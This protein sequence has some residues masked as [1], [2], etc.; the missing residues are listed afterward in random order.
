MAPMRERVGLESIHP[1]IPGRALRNVSERKGRRNCPDRC[2]IAVQ[3]N[4]TGQVDFLQFQ[5]SILIHS[6]AVN[7]VGAGW[8]V[9]ARGNFGIGVGLVTQNA[10]GAVDFLNLDGHGNLKSSAMSNVDVAPII[11]A[12]FFSSD[13]PNQVGPTYV[14]QLANGELDLLAFDAS[15]TLIHSDAIAN[16]IGFA[17]AVGVGEGLNHMPTSMFADVGFPPSQNDNVVL[18]LADGSLDVVG[19]TGNFQG[20]SLTF[21]ASLLLPGSAGSGSVQAVDQQQ[22][23]SSDDNIFGD[24]GQGGDF[25]EGGQFVEQ[26]AN[27]QFDSLWADSGY[28]DLAHEGTI[29]AS[30]LLN[31]TL[32]GWHAVD[33][34]GVAAELF[35]AT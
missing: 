27:G 29:Y 24:V 16:T 28:G 8:N 30:N 23:A 20:S 13:V 18:Q 19:F 17:H 31:L 15:G 4:T 22:G 12:G 10:A 25:L 35:P 14:S 5:G 9:V 3:N 26:L 11:G 7:Y 1:V 2:T 32:P 21:S 34:G 33:A 6:D